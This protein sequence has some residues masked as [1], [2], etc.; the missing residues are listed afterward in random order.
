MK[1]K[2]RTWMILGVLALAAAVSYYL[3]E[4]RGIAQEPSDET[5]VWD[6]EAEQI[7]GVRVIDHA[8]GAVTAL[9]KG[10]GSTWRVTE[11]VS[12]VAEAAECAS[13]V[14]ALA[15]MP[16]RRTIEDP[17]EGELAAYGLITPTYTIEVRAEDG[18]TLRLQVGAHYPSGSYFARRE[19]EQAVILVQD[20]AVE[21]VVRIVEEPPVPEPTPGVPLEGP[22][23]QEP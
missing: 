10:A 5:Y 13:L 11:P 22:T 20:Y 21:D 6:L 17:P 3:L 2:D 12:E 18:R 8:S 19:G 23:L 9:E 15:Y 7:V 14:Y 16:V 1:G 4:V